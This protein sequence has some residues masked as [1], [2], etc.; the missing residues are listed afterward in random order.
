MQNVDGTRHLSHGH[1]QETGISHD[2]HSARAPGKSCE[3]GELSIFVTAI[4]SILSGEKIDGS[5]KDMMQSRG[6]HVSL[7][8]AAKTKDALRSWGD[9]DTSSLIDVTALAWSMTI[10]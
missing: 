9:R 4:E 6:L 7:T 8:S 2:Q 5:R 3:W 10:L 1:S